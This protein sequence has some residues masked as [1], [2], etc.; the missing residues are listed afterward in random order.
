MSYN[1]MG[2]GMTCY[3]N[4]TSGFS[5]ILKHRYTDFWVN[6]ITGDGKLVCLDQEAT[7]PQP[8]PKP[9]A[10]A[11]EPA[12]A[13]TAAT[14][15][16]PAAAKAGAAT[17]T[18][19]WVGNIASQRQAFE[20]LAGPGN[21]AKLQDLLKRIA[22]SLEAGTPSGELS[23]TLDAIEDKQQRTGVHMFFKGKTAAE[24][25][26]LMT[27]TL[28]LK[29]GD[30]TG[31]IKIVHK[32]G[33]GRKRKFGDNAR[34][35][36][37]RSGGAWQGG[38]NA[39]C[40]FVLRKENID[41]HM[42]ISLIARMLHGRPNHFQTAGTKDKR[43]VTCQQ[44]TAWK[45][46]PDRFRSIAPRL[47]QMEIGNFEYVPDRLWLGAASGNFF[48]V[49]LRNL[50]FDKPEDVGS[51][52]AS[53]RDS[54]FINYYGL[55]RFGTGGIPTHRIGAAL[56]RGEWREAVWLI[57]QPDAS[58]ADACNLYLNDGNIE[59]ALKQLPRHMVGERAI[60]EG[61]AKHGKGKLCQCPHR[62]PT[63]PA[64]HVC[65]RLSELALE[66]CRLPPHLHLRAH[67][68]SRRG[69]GPACEEGRKP[70]EWKA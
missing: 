39:Y 54:G 35:E 55:Q 66:P 57:M 69:S 25:P 56:L 9:A 64:E 41:S 32:E 10:I 31:A 62:P 44:V 19:A 1:E 63:Q 27:E 11:A 42:A 24:L 60:L 37:H 43:G 8:A 3:A 40:R 5:G 13:S 20:T 23:A 17:E 16:N 49:A 61:L 58:N 34:D 38:H 7:L 50:E 48:N 51:A 33:R 2:A 28:Q 45:V 70:A 26:R 46:T 67:S 18:P 59:G 14:D 15:E 21:A 22:S 52:A 30:S 65:A 36:G 68:C 12:S 53:L 6:E 47:R 4:Q 29:S